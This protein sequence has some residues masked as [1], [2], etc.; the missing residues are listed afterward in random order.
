MEAVIHKCNFI[1]FILSL[2][3]NNI[4]NTTPAK[5]SLFISN[6]YIDINA[7]FLVTSM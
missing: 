5:F 4:D 2:H 1:S 6:C 7:S 3:N